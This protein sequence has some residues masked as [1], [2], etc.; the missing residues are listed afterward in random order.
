[1][2]F[3]AAS[4]RAPVDTL[5]SD[6]VALMPHDVNEGAALA[7]KRKQTV[8]VPLRVLVS[9]PKVCLLNAPSCYQFASAVDNVTERESDW[10]LVVF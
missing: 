6:R 8:V 3:L 1:M 2:P 9:E 5:Q 10:L 4:C 7:Q